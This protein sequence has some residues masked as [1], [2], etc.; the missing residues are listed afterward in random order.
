M[1]FLTLLQFS[2]D[3]LLRKKK[4]QMLMNHFHDRQLLILGDL[5]SRFG[6][7]KNSKKDFT[8]HKNPDITINKHGRTLNNILVEN[9]DFVIL[10]GLLN[11]NISFDSNFTFYRGNV[12]SQVDAVISN[13]TDNINCMNILKKQI[14]SDHCPL[15]TSC[16]VII[17]P[18]LH[19]VRDCAE[20]F[21][22]YDHNDVSR[23]I[24]PVI[25]LSKIDI[26]NMITSMETLAAN[27]KIE[28]RKDTIDIDDIAAK[29]E[30]G[31]YNACKQNGMKTIN[32]MN[33]EHPNLNNCTSKNFK[34]IAEMN[35]HTYDQ[36]VK[37][38]KERHLY[39]P[40]LLNW[41]KFEGLASKAE[42]D[43]LNIQCNKSWKSA[44]QDS[45]KMWNLID[46]KGKG[47]INKN[48][49]INE[50]TINQYFK[51]IFQSEKTQNNPVLADIIDRIDEYDVTVPDMDKDIE[52]DELESALKCIRRGASFDGLPPDILRLLP[53]SLKEVLLMLIQQIFSKNY[54]K[55]WNTQLLHALTKLGH[56]F[57]NPQLR[58]IA[59][60]PLLC[61]VYDTVM[62]NRFMKWYQPN[63]EQSAQSKQ[64][65]PVTLFTINL[66]IDYAE[67]TDRSLFIGFLD[68][69]KAY[70]YVNRA[71][72]C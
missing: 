58:G 68:F 65:C 43:E 50:S 53:P 39:E 17:K 33:H 32:E 14:Y 36:F 67:E 34:A 62:D 72:S 20:R 4:L 7:T 57:N 71:K 59:V 16:S 12:C 29:I 55:E 21:F 38:G 2:S 60:A 44:K 64:G 11:K 3:T 30:H 5:N 42:N 37:Q 9:P 31:M 15:V 8:Y 25:K 40:Y 47:Q 26:P 49:V 45:K 48:D 24:M 46:W 23:R 52:M 13:A 63:P 54:P 61:R 6:D 35:L 70:D 51:K 27:M 22:S 10:N 1:Y 41:M 28:L 56:A 66:L 69:E 19:L 18:D